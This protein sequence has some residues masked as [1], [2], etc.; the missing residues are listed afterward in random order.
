ML[1]LMKH[2][3]SDETQDCIFYAQLENADK[4]L[5]ILSSILVD[6]KL[7]RCLLKINETGL[8]TTIEHAKIL[9]ASVLVQTGLFKHFIARRGPMDVWLDLQQFLKCLGKFGKKENEESDDMMPSFE[10]LSQT[11]GPIS[12][13][14]RIEDEDSTKVELTAQEVGGISTRC[15]V[16]VLNPGDLIAFPVLTDETQLAKLQFKS[17]LFDEIRAEFDT[18]AEDLGLRLAENEMTF[19]TETLM[20]RQ[21]V[22]VDEHMQDVDSYVF[23]GIASKSFLYRFKLMKKCLKPLLLSHRTCITVSSEGLL[24]I[25]YSIDSESSEAPIIIEF[26]VISRYT[27]E[28]DPYAREHPIDLEELG[29]FN[30]VLQPRSHRND[31]PPNPTEVSMH[32]ERSYV[33]QRP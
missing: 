8:T 14:F 16:Q 18:T 33:P 4:V 5:H 19:W 31:N 23:S 32:L 24:Q 25:Q 1:S 11:T 26:V 30:T 20:G 10:E 17:C 7:Q 29:N 3:S 9:Q 13:S 27:E 12:L 22:T 28:A 21:E 6:D 15:Y 2:V